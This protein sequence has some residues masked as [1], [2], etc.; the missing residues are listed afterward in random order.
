MCEPELPPA[1]E[2]VVDLDACVGEL[3]GGDP[4]HK[5]HHYRI[6]MKHGVGN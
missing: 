6:K 4:F 1:V 2:V 5:I 3:R